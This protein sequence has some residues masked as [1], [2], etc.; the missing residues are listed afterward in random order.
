MTIRRK[1]F[2]GVTALAAGL[3]ALTGCQPAAGKVTNTV[4][5]KCGFGTKATPTDWFIPSGTPKGLVW[6]QHGFTETKADWD[7]FGR[8]IAADGY[9]AMATTLPTADFQGCT[10]QNIGNNRP[11]LDNIATMFAGAGEPDSALTRSWNDATAKAG[12]TGLVLPSTMTFVGHSAGGEAVPYVANELRKEHPSTFAKLR[13]L[14][15]E[16]PV[17]SF[18]GNNL[19]S[20]LNDLNG[21]TLPVYALASPSSTCNNSQSGAKAVS[22]KLTSRS[23]HGSVVTSGT[24]GDVFG[25]SVPGTVTLACGTPQTSNID[26]VQTLSRAWLKD[27]AAGT[28]TADFYPGG[29]TYDAL[30]SAGT[31]TTLP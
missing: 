5:I 23:F 31:I 29:A 3:L 8:K 9:V 21:T 4:A 7:D 16:D 28:T 12:R 17:K 26:A 6:L 20:A 24:H 15:L 14:V 10:V 22:E 2:W 11:F 19:D 27:Q 30:V 25:A 13:G 18:I 1:T